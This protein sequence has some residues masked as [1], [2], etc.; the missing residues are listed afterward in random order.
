MKLITV[1]MVLFVSSTI[2]SNPESGYDDLQSKGIQKITV[3]VGDDTTNGKDKLV[4]TD[5]NV[6]YGKVIKIGEDFIEFERNDNNQVYEYLQKNTRYIVWNENKIQF[7]AHESTNTQKQEIATPVVIEKD[8]GTPVGLIILA[9]LGA[10][11]GVL[12]IVGALAS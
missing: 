9:T 11:L 4:L 1:L 2:W 5:G 6:F 10:L 3:T 7:N 12:L 8:D